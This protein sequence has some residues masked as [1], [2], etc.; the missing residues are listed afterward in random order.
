M[1][2]WYGKVAKIYLKE[3][4][5]THWYYRR[6]DLEDNG[7]DL[8]QYMGEYELVLSDHIS[9]VDMTCVEDHALIVSYDEGNISQRQLPP[10]TPYHR[11][12]VEIKFVKS[13]TK[14]RL[15]DRRPTPV[16]PAIYNDIQLEAE[17]LTMF[18]MPICR[19]GPFGV[20][21]NGS[22]YSRAKLLLREARTHGSM[23]EAWRDILGTI[24]DVDGEC[25]FKVSGMASQS[26]PIAAHYRVPLRAINKKFGL[27]RHIVT[28]L[29]DSRNPLAIQLRDTYLSVMDYMHDVRIAFFTDARGSANPLEAGFRSP[30]MDYYLWLDH[31]VGAF[32]DRSREILEKD[33]NVTFKS[34][35]N[36]EGNDI[37]TL[38]MWSTMNHLDLSLICDEV[39]WN[40]Y[41]T[42]NCN[43]YDLC[44][45]FQGCV[46]EE[47]L[48]RLLHAVD[49]SMDG[50]DVPKESQSPTPV[51]STDKNNQTIS[52]KDTTPVD[53]EKLLDAVDLY[54]TLAPNESAR[55]TVAR[56]TDTV[57]TVNQTTEIPDVVSLGV[58]AGR[59]TPGDAV[60]D[61]ACVESTG[62]SP[63]SACLPKSVLRPF[64]LP[65]DW[66]YCK[67]ALRTMGI[68]ATRVDLSR[69]FIAHI[70]VRLREL[71]GLDEDTPLDDAF[72][73]GSV[74]EATYQEYCELY[75]ISN[76]LSATQTIP[77]ER[78]SIAQFFISA[79]RGLSLSNMRVD[80]AVQ[81][82]AESCGA[83]VDS[84]KTFNDD[85]VQLELCTHHEASE[86]HGADEEYYTKNFA[87][88]DYIS[89]VLPSGIDAECS[90]GRSHIPSH[91]T[92]QSITLDCDNPC[93]S[94]S[95]WTQAAVDISNH[96]YDV[97][98]LHTTSSSDL[99]ADKPSDSD[100]DTVPLTRL[101]SKNL[102]KDK[103]SMTVTDTRRR[104]KSQSQ[105]DIDPQPSL[106][107]PVV[108]A[109]SRSQ[110]KKKARIASPP[111]AK[112]TIQ[113][114]IDAC[115]IDSTSIPPSIHAFLLD[116]KREEFI[117]R[118][119]TSQYDSLLCLARFVASALMKNS[120]SEAVITAATSFMKIEW[121]L[122]DVA[123][124]CKDAS[125]KNDMSL[126]PFAHNVLVE[127]SNRASQD[128]SS[129]R[130]A[131]ENYISVNLRVSQSGADK[132]Y[133]GGFRILATINKARQGNILA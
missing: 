116:P 32:H 26:C 12:N 38:R 94:A 124:E 6:M 42:T 14:V 33:H 51:H 122:E 63:N 79:A 75:G 74:S 129:L 72:Q 111:V 67:R 25:S 128:E 76:F 121:W 95:D 110:G 102:K 90:T 89:D 7:V 43:E 53:S 19:G 10:E 98:A 44:G 22:I 84:D 15:H 103:P 113:D 30:A 100:N 1:S 13:R 132:Q 114:L 46:S 9:L 5:D 24:E 82:D 71:H 107:R 66:N 34:L 126:S 97:P 85:G 81:C 21:G 27:Y 16:L 108:F 3:Q 39:D 69:W 77:Q 99:L 115:Q 80:C 87:L 83:P 105:H 92:E 119:I 131:L 96:Q 36:R 50:S 125:E 28:H 4:G 59:T 86:P 20:V 117:Q 58:Q 88:P 101:R 118:E 62:E 127:L 109:A 57:T 65:F 18:T 31:K 23:P 41:H 106:V 49:S 112:Y 64:P 40:A 60:E 120:L 37:I 11:W 130:T 73:N 35:Q 56:S 104:G 2:Y 8:A 68:K 17:F 52:L 61:D 54:A 91:C 48:Q 93:L 55:T 29:T 123:V 133:E 45:V 47:D 70:V 78:Q